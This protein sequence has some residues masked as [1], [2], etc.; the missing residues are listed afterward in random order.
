MQANTPIYVHPCSSV[1]QVCWCNLVSA[2]FV[3]AVCYLAFVFWLAVGEAKWIFW[4][5][6]LVYNSSFPNN[7]PDWARTWGCRPRSHVQSQR[8]CPP[9][10]C[11]MITNYSRLKKTT[12][13]PTLWKSMKHSPNDQDCLHSMI[14]MRADAHETAPKGSK[15]PLLGCKNRK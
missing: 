4:N 11:V 3:E 1:N 8:Y 6:I 5:L 9:R 12:H 7:S 10:E 13:R 14:K 2:P 15:Q